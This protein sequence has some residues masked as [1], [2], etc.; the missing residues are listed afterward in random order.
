MVVNIRVKIWD[1]LVG[2]YKFRVT[3][4][5]NIDVTCFK[6][7]CT[8]HSIHSLRQWLFNYYILN[9]LST[10]IF[11]AENWHTS[12]KNTLL[13]F[14]YLFNNYVIIYYDPSIV[15][16]LSDRTLTAETWVQSPARSCNLWWGTCYLDNIFF[17]YFV[18][19]P[20]VTFHLC[21]LLILWPILDAV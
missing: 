2:E 20:S 14:G 1:F 16:T 6:Y 7:S 21:S 13:Y 19:C 17:K 15:Q 10:L 4:T 12:R 18:F 9:Y 5:M 8:G 3:T 11:T